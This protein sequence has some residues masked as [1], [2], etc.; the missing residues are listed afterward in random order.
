MINANQLRELIIRPTLKY[1][2][3]EI[4]YSEDAVE[5]LMMTAAHESHLGTYIAQ[6]NGPALGIYQM[7]P[8]TEQDI[9]V[10]FLQF[11]HTLDDKVE[12][13]T[14]DLYEHFIPELMC[15]LAYSTA[16]ARVH[17]YRVP[18]A[19]PTR[20]AIKHPDQKEEVTLD[21]IIAMAK[22]AKKH[23]NTELGKATWQQYADA[24]QRYCL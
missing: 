11:K 16:M 15:N 23:Y 22:Y 14:N 10:N 17:Y 8:A 21:W 24:Y 6:V 20:K 5:L 3:P 2:E 4:P 19:L 1:L 18:E 9:F 13:L 7:E 12:Y